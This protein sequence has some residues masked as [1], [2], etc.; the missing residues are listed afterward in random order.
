M[1]FKMDS[2]RRC[3][4]NENEKGEY[5]Y[6]KYRGI[7]SFPFGK[8]FFCAIKMVRN[9]SI[10]LYFL[11]QIVKKKCTGEVVQWLKILGQPKKMNC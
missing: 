1:S 7:N 4:K 2:K 5:A 6:I 9:Q 8:E 10:Q 11:I 3:F